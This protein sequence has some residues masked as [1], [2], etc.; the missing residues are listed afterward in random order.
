MDILEPRIEQYLKSLLPGADPV[1]AE[2]ERL[3]AERQFPIIGPLVG[4]LCG[5]L[6]R[7]IGARKVFEMG[8]GFGYSTL[9]FARAVGDGGTVVH[10]EGSEG[11]SKLA[12]EFLSKAGVADRVRFEV[13]DAREILDRA[14][15]SGELLP[16]DIIFNDMDKEQYP[17]A[18]PRARKALRPGGLLICDNM[19]WFGRVLDPGNADETT[20]GILELSRQLTQARDFTTTL[21]PIRDGVTV[22]LKL[23]A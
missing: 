12:R 10:T 23:P 21:V 4:N 7:S 17:D 22:S 20:R 3:G 19:L 2:M 8:S 5:L 1:R 18:L 14:I 16:L 6:A 9:W 13:G 15:A 11:N